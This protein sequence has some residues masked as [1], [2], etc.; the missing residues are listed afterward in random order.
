MIDNLRVD[1]CLP[2]FVLMPIALFLSLLQ[3]VKKTNPGISFTEVGKVLGDK[4]NKMSGV[5]T[6][7]ATSLL[8]ISGF[9]YGL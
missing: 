1:N 2:L 6:I 3:N 4:W 7:S 8:C 5:V 9:H